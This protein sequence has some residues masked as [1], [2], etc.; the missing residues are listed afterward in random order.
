[1]LFWEA[2]RENDWKKVVEVTKKY[3]YPFIRR[4][5]HEFW[6]ATLEHFGVAA[7]FLRPPMRSYSDEEMEDVTA[8]FDRQGLDPGKYQ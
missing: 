1:M 4:F 6:H 5:S 8:F 7:R 2:I 3:D